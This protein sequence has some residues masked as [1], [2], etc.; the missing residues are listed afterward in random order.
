MDLLKAPTAPF[1]RSRT[2]S[3]SS[4]RPNLTLRIDA[5]IRSTASSPGPLSVD[6]RAPLPRPLLMSRMRPSSE[7]FLPSPPSAKS[8][9]FRFS[10]I[11]DEEG[12]P[13]IT[14]ASNPKD[15]WYHPAPATGSCKVSTADA[16]SRVDVSASVQNA[17]DNLSVPEASRFIF[18]PV[19][20]STAPPATLRRQTSFLSIKS[21]SSL[22]LRAFSTRSRRFSRA[23]GASARGAGVR[24]QLSPRKRAS[25]F[26]GIDKDVSADKRASAILARHKSGSSESCD[27]SFDDQASKPVLRKAATSVMPWRKKARGETMSM[28]IDSGFFPVREFIYDMGSPSPVGRA[29]KRGQLALSILIKELPAERPSSIIKTP[30]QFYSN[31]APGVARS[32]AKYR[33]SLGIRRRILSTS[34]EL[35]IQ[36]APSV[37]RYTVRTSPFPHP[38]SPLTPLTPSKALSAL[39]GSGPT[40]PSPKSACSLNQ[41]SPGILEAIPEDGGV[42]AARQHVDVPGAPAPP[43]AIKTEI[44]LTSGTV[45]TVTP[46]EVTAWRRSVYI[47]GPIKLPTPSVVPRKGSI[48][49]LDPFQDNLGNSPTPR[50]KSEDNAADDICDWYCEWRFDEVS[51]AL[52]EFMFEDSSAMDRW[53]ITPLLEEPESP[54]DRAFS[55]PVP[56]PLAKEIAAAMMGDSI[57]DSRQHMAENKSLPLAMVPVPELPKTSLFPEANDKRHSRS[58][59]GD[60]SYKSA[61]SEPVS[62]P[63]SRGSDMSGTSSVEEHAWSDVTAG[64]GGDRL[65]GLLKVKPRMSRMRRLVQTASSIL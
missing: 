12:G 60:V 58:S 34:S 3:P 35:H 59:S 10:A 13:R 47:Q 7:L 50:R 55:F 11:I 48:A 17:I 41:L 38:T 39:T 23:V 57:I 22:P 30:T 4:H 62:R 25:H 44:H 53:A 21:T 63:G 28:L 27:P 20:S 2:T 40:P 42:A 18:A 5:D 49:T 24:P 56:P 16:I 31:A 54:I 46:P 8:S 29:S 64:P 15:G 14:G 6:L 43:E 51:F 52:D 9:G 45:L 61:A 37:E 19:R 1:I 32:R 33:R 65:A 36:N 26:S